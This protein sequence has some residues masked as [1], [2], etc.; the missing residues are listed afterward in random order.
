ML[1]R[2]GGAPP[3]HVSGSQRA[4]VAAPA[5]RIRPQETWAVVVGRG[6]KKKAAKPAKPAPPPTGDGRAPR[7]PVGTGAP[8]ASVPRA[9]RTAT[10]AIT[11]PAGGD[12]E[13]EFS[14]RVSAAMAAIDVG[15]LSIPAMRP[16]RAVTGGLVLEIPGAQAAERAAVL[17]DRLL[18]QLGN[19][20][21][22]VHCPRRWRSLGYVA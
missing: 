1:A 2:G 19:S 18:E 16:K 22:R 9:P 7:R 20:G 21:I 13:K 5:S 17:R 12:A 14:T 11:A 4:P 15:Q 8:G 6:A 3:A 10:V